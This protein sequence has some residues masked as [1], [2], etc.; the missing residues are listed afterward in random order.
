MPEEKTERN[1]EIWRRFS[2][3]ERQADLA[4][5][6]G[7]TQQA[8]AHIVARARAKIGPADRAAMIADFVRETQASREFLAEVRN[9]P[10]PPAFSVKGDLLRDER[11]ETVKDITSQLAASREL[12]NQQAHIAKLLGLN[13][14]D[15]VQQDTTVHFTIEGVD[16]DA[17]T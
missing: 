6:F 3:G 7:I 12:V 2:A 11:G 16:G 5:E 13:A 4:E 14:P 9:A 10:P 8:I 15:R 17:L 1:A